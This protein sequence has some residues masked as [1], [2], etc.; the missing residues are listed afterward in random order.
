[1]NRLGI[2]LLSVFGLLLSA[3]VSRPAAGIVIL[4][5]EA[6][7]EYPSRIIFSIEAESESQIRTLELEFGL[8]GRDCTPD[9]NIATP[10]DFS[11]AG[12]VDL[13]WTWTVAA[14]GN[15]PPGMRIWW[16]WRVV[17]AF[18]NEV[19]S[20]KQWITWIDDVHDWRILTSDNIR[21]HWYRGTDAYNRGFLKAAEDA[22]ELLRNDIGAWPSE[23]IHIYI[24]GSNQDLKDALEGEQEWIGG[25][26]FNANQRTIM[27]GIGPEY[28][29]WG[30]T[31]IAHEL[32]HT[33]V[34]SIMG[35]CY[36]SIPLWLNEGIAMYAEGGLEEE[37]QA[38]LDDAVY[39]DSLFSL[40]SISYE[41]QEVDGDPT[42][43][44]AQSY[45]VVK[46]MIEAYGR[47]KIR[48]A[49]DRLGEGYTYDSAL[50]EAFG[51]DMDELEDAWR[52]AIGAD[53]MR[54]QTSA[55]TPTAF[56]DSTLPP[57]SV[58]H[59]VSTITTLP[60][61]ASTPARSGESHIDNAERRIA[62]PGAI[63]IAC[64]LGLT[65]I[66]GIGALGGLLFW[67]GRKSRASGAGR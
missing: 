44:Y 1:M 15:L 49:L 46:F 37:Y 48:Q 2:S 5:A 36:A 14:T 47:K 35:G 18:G 17:D 66:T 58:S 63:L 6:R 20:E 45:S 25:L 51:L 57:A 4:E 50:R 11:P 65:C 19:R 52:K 22:R 27:I 42:R 10:K 39:Y 16:N 31:T 67:R 24:Y 8:T 30:L 28:S 21:L 59:T 26:S 23:E 53:P 55:V 41:Y 7:V 40:R 64:V 60:T 38:S 3:A 33:A 12:H 32:A 29:E 62:S 34:D 56:P 43:M 61:H 9:L 54:K 13:S